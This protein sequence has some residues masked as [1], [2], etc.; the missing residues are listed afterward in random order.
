MLLIRIQDVRQ[1]SSAM[2]RKVISRRDFKGIIVGGGSPCQANS[3]LNRTR[4]GWADERS[5][6]PLELQRI[7]HE[8]ETDPLCAP[9]QSFHSWRTLPACLLM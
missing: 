8:L 2:L 3:Y 7:I 9:P 6:M 4:K 1:L 5:Q